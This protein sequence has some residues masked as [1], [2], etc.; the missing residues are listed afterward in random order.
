MKPWKGNKRRRSEKPMKQ[1]K[2]WLLRAAK[3]L[4]RPTSRNRTPSKLSRA[5]AGVGLPSGSLSNGSPGVSGELAQELAEVQSPF[6]AYQVEMGV[7]SGRLREDFIAAQREVNGVSAALAKANAKVEFLFGKGDCTHG[8][9]ISLIRF[10]RQAA[11][12]RRAV[13]RT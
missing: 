6:S 5:D 8:F 2:N 12:A 9:P 1:G 7:D 4:S 13:P 11:D 10:N 3:V